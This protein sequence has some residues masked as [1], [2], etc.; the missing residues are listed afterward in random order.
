MGWHIY[1]NTR[2]VLGLVGCGRGEHRHPSAGPE[3]LLLS[4]LALCAGCADER[5][6]VIVLNSSHPTLGMP[7]A[8]RCGIRTFVSIPF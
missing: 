1:I 7:F 5:R 8:V 4:L 3:K 2:K 6:R